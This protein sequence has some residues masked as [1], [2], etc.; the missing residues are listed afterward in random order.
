MINTAGVAAHLVESEYD[1]VGA[2]TEEGTMWTHRFA[3][4]YQVATK[5]WGGEYEG[6]HS[7]TVA[8]IE[9]QKESTHNAVV[10]GDK[11]LKI[12]RSK[13]LVDGTRRFAVEVATQIHAAAHGLAPRVLDY[14]WMVDKSGEHTVFILMERFGASLAQ[15]PPR[16]HTKSFSAAL[17]DLVSQCHS[18]GIFPHDLSRDNVLWDGSDLKLIDFD[19]GETS[20]C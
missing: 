6:A 18:V 7:R 4:M 1:A 10:E 16:Y 13:Y 8:L 17:K 12:M 20:I 14:G 9:V 11:V 15:K 2:W 5:N 19:P 3:T